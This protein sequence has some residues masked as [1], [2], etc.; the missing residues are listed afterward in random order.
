MLSRVISGPLAHA[1]GS[2]LWD[3][4]GGALE[5]ASAYFRK[6]AYDAGTAIEEPLPDGRGS[7][8]SRNKPLSR[9]TGARMILREGPS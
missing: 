8:G 4:K 5:F 7:E 2:V 9:Q 1:R 3:I 6:F